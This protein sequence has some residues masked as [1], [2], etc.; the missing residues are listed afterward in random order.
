MSC[1]PGRAVAGSPLPRDRS[2]PGRLLA[3]WR[4]GTRCAWRA[5]QRG[6]LCATW[7]LA[8]AG[9]WVPA[10]A[11]APEPAIESDATAPSPTPRG[12]A[13]VTVLNRT[14]AVFRAP[15]LGVSTDD[16]AF[17]TARTIHEILDK[18]G[19]GVVT[20]KTSPNGVLILIDGELALI[21]TPDDTDRLRNTSLDATAQAAV[22]KLER[23]IAET[24]ELRDRG[25]IARSVAAAAAAT[26]AFAVG[27]WL[28]WRARQWM[29]RRATEAARRAASGVSLAGAPLLHGEGVA[30][31]AAAF[32][33][34]LTWAIIVLIAYE[35]L[36]YVLSQFPYT[37][38]WGEG[39]RD[40]F[41]SVALKLGRNMLGAMPDLFVAAV[42]FL[43]AKA[44]IG[45][46]DPYFELAQSGQV[47]F[48]W[49]Q[50][51]MAR[52]TRQL[53]RITVWLFTIAMAYPYLPGADSEAF[54]GISVL[55]GLAV[56]VGGSGLF[57]QAFSGLV[58]LY[59][60]TIRVGEYV[61]INE[62]EG[63]V[64][65]LRTFTTRLRTGLGEE[66]TLPNA[67]I[68]A[69]VTKNYSRAVHGPGYIVDTTVT[70]GY[71]TPWRQVQTLLV[72]AARRTEGVLSEPAPR[73]FQTALSDFYPEY[74]LVC[75]AIPSQPRPRAEVLATLH[76]NIQDVFNEQGIQIM[77]P[78]YRG[79][80]QVPKI[81][82]ADQWY[83]P[84]AAK[85]APGSQ[86]EDGPKS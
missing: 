64:T 44:V 37:R 69:T 35:W 51:D 40:F 57:G 53:F 17:R 22:D 59:S 13:P 23:V 48:S 79:D 6:V 14:I 43:I 32:V 26:L 60:R 46:V 38:P 84:P 71:D 42:M 11:A 25:R 62:H 72:E 4:A 2:G 77:S 8:A 49:L 21:L 85:P 30:G 66:L 1:S 10:L 58:L 24:R 27:V 39:L 76:A 65:E 80:P 54:K 82:P 81:V 63:T 29:Q 75:Q 56:T 3:R 34:F 68:L 50:G 86:A 61:R 47:R 67:L 33:R 74:R 9:A 7:L 20:T 52:P 16:R 28:V 12:E 19:P 45:L 31:L 5:A 36:G 15:F 18:G 73:V 55:V 83:P 41:V 70:I 78:H